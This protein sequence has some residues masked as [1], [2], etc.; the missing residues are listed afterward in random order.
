[1]FCVNSD[2]QSQKGLYDDFFNSSKPR[3]AIFHRTLDPKGQVTSGRKYAPGGSPVPGQQF[4][5][6]FDDIGNRKS[7]DRNDNS[8]T[9]TANSVNQ[10]TERTIPN[11]LSITG[12][13]AADAKVRIQQVSLGDEA[14]TSPNR[15]GKYFDKEY[16]FE[17]STSAITDT[18][19]VFATRFDQGENKDVVDEESLNVFV[20]KTPELY[21]YDD[22]GN[23]TGDGQFDYVWNGENRLISATPKTLVDGA[24]KIEFVHDYMGRRTSKKTHTYNLGTTSWDLTKTEKIVWD[25]F[26]KIAILDE[27]NAL[28]KSMLWGEDLSG[29]LQGAGGVGGLLEVTDHSG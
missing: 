12:S 13:A 22:D 16:T 27:A 7:E 6:D 14:I 20:P 11:K 17:N 28:Q 24:K 21:T 8:Y 3:M 10:Y 25:N 5:Y 19:K 18:F 1:M 29:T 26:N 2:Y 9:Y 23:M 15:N 4:T